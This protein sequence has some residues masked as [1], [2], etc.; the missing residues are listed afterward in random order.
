MKKNKNK[1]NI[2]MELENSLNQIYKMKFLFD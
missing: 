1:D 2:E